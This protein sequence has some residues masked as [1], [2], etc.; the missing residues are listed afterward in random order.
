[1][2]IHPF[3]F[4]VLVISV[5]FGVIL[6]FQSTGIWSTSGKVNASGEAVQPLAADP[7]SI[8]GWMTLDQI[9]M[10]YQV[11]LEEL[12]AKFSLP[13]DT[14][15]TT[16]I[17]D[18][19]SDTFE[20]EGLRSWLQE[21]IDQGVDTSIDMPVSVT[22]TP[23]KTEPPVIAPTSTQAAEQSTHEPAIN[24]VTGKTTFQD[25]IDWGVSIEAIETILGDT[26]PEPSMIVKD[27][28]SAKGLEFS[29]VKTL[30]QT[31]VDKP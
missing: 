10:T 12:L 13:A 2:R 5:F 26:L 25:L 8:K 22:P 31:E 4:G 1:M 11:P 20:T 30:L 9:A 24:T 14:P 29:S 21:R 28:V 7:A 19:E 27:Y 23:I 16:A 17:K 18:L 3:I 6:G 15:P